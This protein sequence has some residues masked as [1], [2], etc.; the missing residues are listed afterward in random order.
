MHRAKLDNNEELLKFCQTLEFATVQT[1]E[2][3]ILTKDLAI[4]VFNRWDVKEK[5]HWLVTEDFMDK[6]DE[7]F[8]KEW[9]KIVG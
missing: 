5:E 2:S 1:M 8:Q 3:G 7:N 6:I 9:K 4:S